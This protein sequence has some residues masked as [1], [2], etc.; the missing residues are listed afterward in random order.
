MP[1]SRHHAV[2][3]LFL[4]VAASPGCVASEHPL[5][6]AESSK[7]DEDLIGE[8]CC[9]EDESILGTIRKKADSETVLELV[10]GTNGDTS[11]LYCTQIAEERYCTV[12]DLRYK[13]YR[14]IRYST[15]GADEI[16]R[17]YAL[18]VDAVSHAIRAG[19]VAG[20]TWNFFGPQAKLTGAPEELR[21]YIEKHAKECFEPFSDLG[22]RR[23]TNP[24]Q[25]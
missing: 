4:F 14:I 6:D 17:I 15:R 25:P 3:M 7:I 12:V 5:T 2:V 13:D 18:D 9:V 1:S 21:A 20:K 8:W 11:T 19:W 10:D 22:L 23:A 24:K 16:I